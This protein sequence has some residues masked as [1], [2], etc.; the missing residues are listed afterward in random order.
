MKKIDLREF[1]LVVIS[2]DYESIEVIAAYDGGR[3]DPQSE[4]RANVYLIKRRSSGNQL[5]L[6]EPC[7]EFLQI[8]SKESGALEERDLVVVKIDPR[9][10]RFLYVPE[11]VEIPEGSKVILGE[12]KSLQY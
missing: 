7:R 11:D 8:S 9:I 4:M 1:D 5:F 12:I 3:C 10:N 2:S 6:I